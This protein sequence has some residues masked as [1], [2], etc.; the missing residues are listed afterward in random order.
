MLGAQLS[1]HN[2]KY[3]SS[4]T[5]GFRVLNVCRIYV[6]VRGCVRMVVHLTSLKLKYRQ[7]EAKPI[8]PEGQK[9]LLLQQRSPKTPQ[10]GQSPRK[11]KAKKPR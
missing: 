8:T 5:C 11:Q 7:M 9:A 1:K 4:H 3:N 10:K 2:T 6:Y